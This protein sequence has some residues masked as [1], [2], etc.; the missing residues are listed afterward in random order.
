M[1]D[2]T[3]TGLASGTSGSPQLSLQNEEL[4]ARAKENEKNINIKQE[5]LKE[6]I[7]KDGHI[8]LE[9]I[10][11]RREFFLGKSVKK[12]DAYLHNQGYETN[13][14]PSKHTTS[15]A[16]IIVTTNSTAQRNIAQVQVSPGSKRHG[17]IPYVKIS[18]KDIGIIKIIDGTK[19]Q[20]KSDGHEKAK[21][22]FRRYGRK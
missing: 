14:R 6:P 2:G 11:K 21:L 18:T 17:D 22:L 8:T 4:V 10:S 19:E 1:A 5:A 3:N 13:I 7:I 16:K 15:K 9:S 20:Y 12:I